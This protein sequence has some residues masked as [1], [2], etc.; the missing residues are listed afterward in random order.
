MFFV[1]FSVP[2]KVLKYYLATTASFHMLSNSS[3]TYHTC[4]HRAGTVLPFS[5]SWKGRVFY[6]RRAVVI[7]SL[8]Y[9][10]AAY[11]D[12]RHFLVVEELIRPLLETKLHVV[13]FRFVQVLGIIRRP[14]Q[15]CRC[16]RQLVP[17]VRRSTQ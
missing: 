7:L 14:V 9:T 1:V 16:P 4:I 3:F 2:S 12:P 13:M 6:F 15:P 5:F 10:T 11:L 8:Q 17:I